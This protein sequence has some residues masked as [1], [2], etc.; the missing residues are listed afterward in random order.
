MVLAGSVF[1]VG[2]PSH[3]TTVLHAHDKFNAA[4]AGPS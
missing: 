3:R 2:N 4:D 1:S